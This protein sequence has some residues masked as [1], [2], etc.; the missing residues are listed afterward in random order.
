MEKPIS[1]CCIIRTWE[2]MAAA[3]EERAAGS[4]TSSLDALPRNAIH[5]FYL[6]KRSFIWSQCIV[7]FL[8]LV[9]LCSMR[10]IGSL[11]RDQTRSPPQGIGV[12]TSGL[13]GKSDH[14]VLLKFRIILSLIMS[15]LLILFL[16]TLFL[17]TSSVS[18]LKCRQRIESRLFNEKGFYEGRLESPDNHQ[19]GWR[20]RFEAKYQ[21]SQNPAV[22]FCNAE[23]TV[24]TADPR[25]T[26]LKPT[27]PAEWMSGP[28]LLYRCF[29][30]ST[31]RGRN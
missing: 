30:T 31:R 3:A 21:Q 19:K 29:L 25:T 18:I 24:P 5:D 16:W 14:N 10:D 15:P 7:L 28:C 12:L 4:H 9:V 13:S 1:Y 8:F 26:T 22:F 6:L 11:T 17:L 23:D 20:N 2:S 27:V